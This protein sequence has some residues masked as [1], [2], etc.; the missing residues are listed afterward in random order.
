[1]AS[2]LAAEAIVGTQFSGW[3]K[4]QDNETSFVK[5]QPWHI[6][7]AKC[8]ALG[9]T[10][11]EIATFCDKSAP[12][13]YNLMRAPHFQ[14]RLRTY[15]EESGTSMAEMFAGAAPGA[16]ATLV[17]I[18]N[19]PKVSPAVRVSSAKEILDR[20]MGK[21]T[22]YIDSKVQNVTADVHAREAELLKEIE[23][24]KKALNMEPDDF[25][26]RTSSN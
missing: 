11:K 17:E 20:H 5:E 12:S 13:V 10:P 14:A 2:P 26:P 1:M 6:Q 24:N 4:G 21:S 18:C 7:A 16:Y 22:Q 23:L 15:M 9:M 8:M 3:Q 19:D 25:S